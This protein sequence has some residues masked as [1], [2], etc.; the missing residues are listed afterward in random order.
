MAKTKKWI[1]IALAVGI[2]IAIFSP[3]NNTNAES[4]SHSQP[5]YTLSENQSILLSNIIVN[6]FNAAMRGDKT[7]ISFNII[8]TNPI[9][10]AY[11]YQRNEVLGDEK[12][13]KKSIYL[14]ATVQKI[15]SGLG[16]EPYLVLVGGNG[17][18]NPI[19]KFDN[20]S[21][22]RSEISSLRPYQSI[23]LVCTGGGVLIG[24]PLFT[25][26]QFASNYLGQQITA[27]RDEV[28]RFL[29]GKKVTSQS[30]LVGAY[31]AVAVIGVS[32]YLPD[33]SACY[34]K[35]ESSQCAKI[36]LKMKKELDSDESHKKVYEQLKS[37]GIDIKQSLSDFKD[38]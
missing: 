31:L 5:K 19:A 15:N 35:G 27:I 6:E 37:H 34:K 12:Y 36:I 33:N 20:K 21:V 9:N 7:L 4:S 13:Y 16:N 30:E 25:H 24:S 26:C 22:E 10:V 23:Q 17:F 8:P 29:S 14:A 2:L 11:D 1:I 38:A 3:E 18:N 32:N 28:Y